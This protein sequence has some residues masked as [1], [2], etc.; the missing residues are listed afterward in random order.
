MY[1][2]QERST[3]PGIFAVSIL[4]L[5]TVPTVARALVTSEYP[6]EQ[7]LLSPQT[8]TTPAAPWSQSI[9]DLMTQSTSLQYQY[10][11]LSINRQDLVFTHF[12][13]QATA[14]DITGEDGRYRAQAFTH[15]SASPQAYSYTNSS[16]SPTE[17]SYGGTL[18]LDGWE[19]FAL[20]AGY[21]GGNLQ[22][23]EED[24]RFNPQPTTG[25]D[26]WNLATTGFWLDRSLLARVEYAR[27]TA[28]N[29]ASDSRGDSVT[30]QALQAEMRVSS[31]GELGSGWLD[32]WSGSALYRSVD[33]LYYSLGNSELTKGLDTAQLLMQSE[34]RR[35]TIELEWKQEGIYPEEGIL[36]FAPTNNRSGMRLQYQLDTPLSPL[37]GETTVAARHYRLTQWQTQSQIDLQGYALRQAGDE[38]GLNLAFN[39]LRWHWNVDYL[40]AQLDHWKQPQT[41]G[42]NRLW[43]PEADWL[44]TTVAF[45]LGI[46]LTD[47]FWMNFNA[48]QNDQ[49][50]LDL[51]RETQYQN[52]GVQFHV[53][54]L[55]RNLKLFAEY[56]FADETGT[57]SAADSDT[58]RW[59]SQTGNAQLTWQVQ[60]RKAKRPALDVYL[61]SGVNHQFNLAGDLNDTQW[62]AHIGFDLRWD[63]R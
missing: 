10:Q 14:A 46:N 56:Y 52:L 6:L 53:D 45:N 57:E 3:I 31:D 49:Q 20:Q 5:C 22:W 33:N 55:A 36:G 50:A 30:G 59:R 58:T 29:I 11:P 9:P 34:W 18:E 8:Q 35:L 37:L 7:P 54:K 24:L 4:A 25:S 39:H 51:A 28:E 2:R 16:S 62:T 13:R 48:Q 15:Q 1:S 17:V 47:R 38:S 12:Q 21:L 26:S 44:H 40:I 60:P 42:A 27:S 23:T 32:R 19:H 61:R 43:Q 41:P 63:A